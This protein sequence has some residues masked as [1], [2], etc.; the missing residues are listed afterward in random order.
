MN[1]QCSRMKKKQ[2]EIEKRKERYHGS[3]SVPARMRKGAS[4]LLNWRTWTRKKKRKETEMKR[5]EVEKQSRERDQVGTTIATRQ[6]PNATRLSAQQV[7]NEFHKMLYGGWDRIKHEGSLL[8]CAHA[9][10]AKI[11]WYVLTG[12]NLY[13]SHREGLKGRHLTGRMGDILKRRIADR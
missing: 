6:C 10:T 1:C 9:I 13:A 11:S 4:S 3:M 7:I 12:S 2:T 8:P 5:E